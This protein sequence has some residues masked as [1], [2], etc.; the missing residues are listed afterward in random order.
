M[1]NSLNVDLE[2]QS[3]IESINLLEEKI[4]S[5][6]LEIAKAENNYTSSNPVY[7]D[8]INQKDV[9]LEQ[10]TG[11]EAEIRQLPIAQQEYI[12]LFRE[13]EIAQLLYSELSNKK[14]EYSIL[15][16]S[17]L[18]NM[19][20]VDNAYVDIKLSPLLSSIFIFSVVFSFI[21]ILFAV[22]RGL[23]LIPI[24][25]PAE[26]P[27]NNINLPIC[28]VVPEIEQDNEEAQTLDDERFN[29]SIESIVVNLNQI[30]KPIQKDGE[31]TV[32]LFTS[33]TPSNGKSF[34]SFHLSKRLTRIGKKFSCRCR[35]KKRIS[36]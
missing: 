13:V 27:D 16:A 23:F 5:I 4:S 2:V 31:A 28:G 12:D 1:N 8:L 3:I 29:Q 9:L 17:T 34:I 21:S 15:E 6:E 32:F 10:K 26:L 35:S 20:I 24:S 14:L 7:L 19:G 11:I 22:F 30:E 18:G 25:N 36:A 33:A